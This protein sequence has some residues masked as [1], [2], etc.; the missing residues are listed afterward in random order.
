[1]NP[2]EIENKRALL[3]FE[4]MEPFEAGLV[5]N[6]AEVKSL[7]AGK[8]SFQGSHLSL[9]QHKP[10]LVNLN[11]S[12]YPK[13]RGDMSPKRPRA[14]LLHQKEISRLAG[15]AQQKGIA[16]IPLRI[17]FKNQFAKVELAVAKGKS[18]RDRRETLK[19]KSQERDIEVE[20]RGK[21]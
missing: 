19:K 1:M 5:L 17:Y 9:L 11:I 16:I 21:R 7:R 13:A 4:I 2:N 12:P 8:V 18:K 14:L 6:G 20:L 15:L 3:A 10:V